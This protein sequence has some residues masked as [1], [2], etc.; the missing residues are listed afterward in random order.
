MLDVFRTFTEFLRVCHRK[1]QCASK[2]LLEDDHP[3]VQA[4][5]KRLQ[6]EAAARS[7]TGFS[8]TGPMEIARAAGIQWGSFPAKPMLSES[9]W[10]QTLTKQQMTTLNYSMVAQPGLHFFRDL[11]PSF[12]RTRV[13]PTEDEDL[14]HV[15]IASTVMPTQMLMI[16]DH[17]NQQRTPRIVLG[18][19]SL[20]LRGFPLDVIDDMKGD[21]L[22]E[23]LFTDLAGNM[24]ST[25]IFLAMAQ[26]IMAAVSWQP[27]C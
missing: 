11:R 23:P 21:F 25:P 8:Y 12:G 15:V 1:P 27:C 13:S 2:F 7:E 6:G 9:P 4:E 18:R 10:Y 5:L 19:E 24:V 22:K 14:K 16:F 3:H 20:W 26:S 17:M